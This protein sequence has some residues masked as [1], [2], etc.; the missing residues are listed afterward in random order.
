MT[1]TEKPLVYFILGAT[2]SGRREVVR[3]LIA[4]GLTE[5]DQAAVLV[6][7]AEAAQE[8]EAKLPNLARWSWTEHGTIAA[9]VPPEATH[10]FLM[11]DGRRNPVDQTEAL[12]PW[13]EANGV[14][15]SRII[16]VV[17]CK[18]AAAHPPLLAWFDAC[19]HFSDVVLL[20]RR[21]DVENKWVSDFQKRYADQ[22]YPCLFEMVKK[23][24]VKNALVILDPVARRIS[25]Y[26]EDEVGWIV[27]GEDDE[28]EAEEGEVEMTQAEDPYLER[29][30]G[31]RRIK[32]IP[33]IATILPTE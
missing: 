20:N 9:V 31:G 8:I 12:K 2:G 7:D 26:F 4:S 16:C 10:V 11:A 5:G 1:P 22:F 27:E 13:L 18:L 33:D 23:G 3:D 17:D 21:E 25:Q 19:V 15:L 6:S 24:R 32:E 30:A 14:E 28:N 29:R